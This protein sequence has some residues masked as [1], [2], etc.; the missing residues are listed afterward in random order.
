MRWRH[1]RSAT[2]SSPEML[3]WIGAGDPDPHGRQGWTSLFGARPLEGQRDQKSPLRRCFKPRPPLSAG[4]AGFASGCRSRWLRKLDRFLRRLSGLLSGCPPTDT[5][6]QARAKLGDARNNRCG[7]DLQENSAAWANVFW[8]A[9]LRPRFEY[10]LGG[11][12][13]PQRGGRREPPSGRIRPR[14]ASEAAMPEHQDK[15]FTCT[16]CNAQY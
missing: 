14:T 9:A 11:R 16:N 12:R 8:R 13:L 15:L 1:E 10:N 2:G 3:P 5:R 7:H 6:P 4:C